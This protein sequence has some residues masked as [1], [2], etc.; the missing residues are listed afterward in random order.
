MREDGKIDYLELPGGD[1][2]ATKS[3]YQ[4]AF[5]WRFTDYGPN[6]AAFGVEQAGLDGG[7]PT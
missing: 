4:Q 1:L 6:Y 3:F 5:G 7:L 2:A